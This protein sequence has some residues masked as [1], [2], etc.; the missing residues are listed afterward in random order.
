MSRIT[1]A[2]PSPSIEKALPVKGSA[3]GSEKPWVVSEGP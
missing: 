2:V 1:L 3:K